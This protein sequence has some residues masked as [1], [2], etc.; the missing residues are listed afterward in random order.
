MDR[1]YLGLLLGGGM[2]R[3]EISNEPANLSLMNTLVFS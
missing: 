3:L 2:G 1:S